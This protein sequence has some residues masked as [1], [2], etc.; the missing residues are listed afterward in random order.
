MWRNSLIVYYDIIAT[1]DFSMNFH[2]RL[3]WIF[4]LAEKL[5]EEQNIQLSS[6]SI[7][8][9]HVYGYAYINCKTHVKFDYAKRQL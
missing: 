2:D 3:T 4:I 7:V 9:I 5:S 1:L 6:F 8:Q